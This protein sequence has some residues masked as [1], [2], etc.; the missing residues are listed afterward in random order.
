MTSIIPEEL[1]RVGTHALVIGVSAYRH[2]KDAPAE[3]VMG[4]RFGVGQLTCAAHSAGR[5]AQWLLQDYRNPRAPLG[6]LRVLLSPSEAETLDPALAAKLPADFAATRS[7]AEAALKGFRDACDADPDN[8][9]IVYIAGHGVQL[10]KHGA[11]VLLE[12]FADNS[13]LNELHGAI[14]VRGCHDGM[15]HSATAKTQFWFSDACRQLPRIAAQFE[16]MAGAL[17]LSSKSGSV[18]ASPLFLSSSTREASFGRPA[19]QTLFNEALLWALGG[20][21]AS[22]PSTQAEL[23]CADWH[24]PVSQLVSK[25]GGKV[26]ELARAH[27][28]EQFVEPTGRVEEAVLHTYAAPPPVDLEILLSP[29][30]ADPVPH[31]SLLRNATEPV[32]QDGVTWPVDMKVDAGLYLLDVKTPQGGEVDKTLLDVAPPRLTYTVEVV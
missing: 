2:V 27:G 6:S 4:R 3:T 18:L 29:P 30:N 25:L 22:G 17:T 16:T 9:G 10:N 11:I 13:H 24:V 21:A 26:R 1:R 5:F 31:H 14:D 12:D 7:N 32:I 23:S 19:G 8:V 20:G 15:N 28:A